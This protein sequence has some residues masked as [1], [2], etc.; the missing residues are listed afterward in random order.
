MKGLELLLSGEGSGGLER[1][2]KFCS[3]GDMIS[4]GGSAED[5]ATTRVRCAWGKFNEPKPVL[6][7]KGTSLKLKEKI[8]KACVQRVLVH[9]SETWPVKEED[10]KRL[11]RNEMWMVRRMCG[12]KLSDRKRNEYLRSRLGIKCVVEV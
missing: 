6:A 12:V 7:E 8:Y 11:E 4:A 5:A 9:G 1:V 10:A 2:T 3:L